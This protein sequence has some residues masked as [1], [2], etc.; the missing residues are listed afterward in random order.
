M[1]IAKCPIKPK[2]LIC[3]RVIGTPGDVILTQA[4]D[5]VIFPEESIKPE[6][7]FKKVVIPP[8]HAWI[9]GDNSANSSDSRHYGP[10][11]QGL[12]LSR[13]VFRLFPIQTVG[14]I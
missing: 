12:I 13:V 9:E 7:H 8:G 14:F 11:P 6:L 2:Q 5:V 10:I 3:K 1:V 4:T